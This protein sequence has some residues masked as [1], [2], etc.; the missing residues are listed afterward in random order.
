MS[1][2]VVLVTQ[3]S[4]TIFQYFMNE[5]S[6]PALQD[7]RVREALDI[8]IDRDA[9]IDKLAF[10]E[11]KVCG[12][13]SW[14][15]EFWSLPQD[16]LRERYKRDVAKARQLLEAAGA[17]DLT[18][19]LKFY[20]GSPTDLAAMIEGSDGRGWYHHQSGPRGNR[21][22]VRGSGFAELRVD[23]SRTNTLPQ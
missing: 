4:L 10:G 21:Y 15:L 20:P 3:P 7:V 8:S 6:Q 17:T 14:G 11:G 12:P 19:S 16:E 22:L 13:V 18:L 23:V 5:L 9:M 2:D 1:K